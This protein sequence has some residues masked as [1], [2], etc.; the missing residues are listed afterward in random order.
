M[1]KE[2][3]FGII[4]FNIL[5]NMQNK[6]FII[7]NVFLLVSCLIMTNIDN[8][9]DLLES[10]DINLFNEEIVLEIVDKENLVGDKF[11]AKFDEEDKVEIKFIAEQEYTE[12]TIPDNLVVIEVASDPETIIAGKVISKEV[13]DYK[14]YD[15]VFDVFEE[16]RAE[17]FAKKNDIELEELEIMNSEVNVET[18]MLA[19]DQENYEKKEMIN[20]LVL[21]WWILFV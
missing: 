7:L 21:S 20:S 15:P 11:E 17:L 6:W 4:K 12:D 9:K 10:H 3:V 18:I 1:N 13:P 8:I 19:V 16:I 2:K 14:L 5:R